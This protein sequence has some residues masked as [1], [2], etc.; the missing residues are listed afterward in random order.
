M[1]EKNQNRITSF[2]VKPTDTDSL[3]ELDKLTKHSTKTR[4][5]FSFLI[6]QAVQNF[7]KEL[8]LNDN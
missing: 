6:L 4:I 3:E 7:N 5:S 1:T 2:S 8:G